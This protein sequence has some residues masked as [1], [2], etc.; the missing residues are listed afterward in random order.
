MWRH[1]RLQEMK[2]LFRCVE[3]LA[4][5][6]LLSWSSARLAAA[7]RL[8]GDLLR[9]LAAL[10]LSPRFVFL[11][12]NAIV[13]V[14]FAKSGH[15]SPSRAAASS[16]AGGG[17][18]YDEFVDRRRQMMQCSAAEV[19]YEDKKVCVE[20]RA[21][22]KSQSERLERGPIEPELRW[23]WT[24]IEGSGPKQPLA[25]EEDA[26]EFRRTVEAF[27]A[28][29]LRFHRQESMSTAVASSAGTAEPDK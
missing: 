29:Q 25:S 12:G 19:V 7:A 13:L 14:L 8:S 28:K 17:D 2:R 26:E 23:S 27:I 11:L 20:G 18:I 4:A 10:L 9:R 6:L 22:R 3:A 15:S 1:R 21:C 24:E 5:V 16:P